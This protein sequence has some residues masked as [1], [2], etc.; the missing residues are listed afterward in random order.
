MSRLLFI[1]DKLVFYDTNKEHLEVLL[2]WLQAVSELNLN[3]HKSKSIP[4]GEVP[5][6]RIWLES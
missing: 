5:K 1:D 2:M 3:L 6:L 4:M